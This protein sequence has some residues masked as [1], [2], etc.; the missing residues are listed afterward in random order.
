MARTVS[1]PIYFPDWLY[2]ILR[3]IKHAIVSPPSQSAPVNIVGERNVEWAFLSTQ[4]PNGPGEAIEF[5]CEQGYMSLL[6]AQKGFHVVANDLQEQ[7]FTWQHPD[8]EFLQGDFLKL[9]LPF[10]HFD[11][12]I[13]CSS[14]EHVGIA[15]RYGIEVEQSQGDI[16]VMHRFAQIL[17]PG[18]V[19]LMTAPCGRD[20]V[21][22][23]LCR[24]YGP[25]RL[26]KLFA[27]FSVVKQEYWIKDEMNRWVRCSREAALSFR[28]T[29][30][31]RDPHGCSYALGCFVLRKK[32]EVSVASESGNLRDASL[33]DA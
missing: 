24:V 27:S 17:K 14:V 4:M 15:G 5:G 19:L 23:P 32:L 22:A 9:T 21:M 28:P 18:G 2:R 12:A 20:A 1:I 16:E 29:Q 11:M 25:E 30:H 6:A 10:N 8:V 13:N 7:S 31:A 33:K 3:S 26:P